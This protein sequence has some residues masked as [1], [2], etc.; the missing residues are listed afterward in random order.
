MEQSAADGGV[1]VNDAALSVLVTAFTKTHGDPPTAAALAALLTA[2]GVVETGSASLRDLASDAKIIAAI[3][4][5]AETA[6]D[7]LLAARQEEGAALFAI[8]S[9][10]L[11]EMAALTETAETLA[12][13]QP[14]LLKEKLEKQLAELDADKTVD[15]D[16]LAVEVALSA[17]KASLSAMRTRRSIAPEPSS[18]SIA[19]WATVRFCS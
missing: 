8:M 14:R 13:T 15:A 1:T 18:S 11:D 16:R 12:E 5:G 2:K 9:G 19:R 3:T 7:Q 6:L 17:A 4:T 10:L